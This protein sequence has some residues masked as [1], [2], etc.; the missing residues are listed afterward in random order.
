[1]CLKLGYT[2]TYQRIVYFEWTSFFHERLK[3]LGQRKANSVAQV[4]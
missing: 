2:V 3:T 4:G 1:M